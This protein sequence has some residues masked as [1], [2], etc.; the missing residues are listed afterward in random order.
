M[1][2]WPHPLSTDSDI[3]GGGGDVDPNNSRGPVENFRAVLWGSKPFRYNGVMNKEEFLNEMSN[4][5][6]EV[7]DQVEHDFDLGESCY[8]PTE[9]SKQPIKTRYLDHVTGYQPTSDHTSVSWFG[10]FLS[11]AN[12]CA[13]KFPSPI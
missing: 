12:H 13:G 1:F 8:E 10:R 4:V 6:V 11:H 9:S 3:G 5:G 2:T 7:L